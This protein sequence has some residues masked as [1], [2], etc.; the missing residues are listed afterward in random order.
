[1]KI[2]AMVPARMGSTRLKMKNLALLNN[3]PVISYVLE[4]AK[5]AQIFDKIFI[6]SES[7]KFEEIAN[8]F[9]VDF[10]HRAQELG[11]STAKS[12]H[13]VYDFMKNNSCDI[14]VWVNSIAP[15][16]SSIEMKSVVDYF[17]KNNLD[18]LITVRD[19]Q[20]HSLLGDKPLNFDPNDE[21]AQTQDL[22]PVRR[23]V[24]SIMM[25]RNRTF[26]HTMEEKGA[27]LLSGKV[28]YYN[29]SKESSL[30]LKT[31]ED[32]YLIDCILRGREITPENK[33]E[34]YSLDSEGK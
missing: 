11:S 15:L 30:I 31:Q 19:E 23:F 3:R 32:L 17:I 6:N 20:V 16:Q 29:V 22:V 8:K 13:V 33:V 7:K 14:T 25:W 24:Y 28:G 26:M 1:M 21:F 4:S 2:Y 12:D 9:E 10:Y 5:K 34:Y 18:S 27:A